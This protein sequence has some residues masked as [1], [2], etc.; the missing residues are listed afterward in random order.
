MF[1]TYIAYVA[2]VER[3]CRGY[4]IRR[5][6]GALGLGD[7]LGLSGGVEATLH[8]GEEVHHGL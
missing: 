2:M 5:Q 4:E 8:L 7:N 3:C 6:P 1:Q